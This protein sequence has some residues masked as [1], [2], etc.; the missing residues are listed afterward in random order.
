MQHSTDDNRATQPLATHVNTHRDNCDTHTRYLR[1]HKLMCLQMGLLP[2]LSTDMSSEP[3][4]V[5][6]VPEFTQFMSQQG[7]V[8]VVA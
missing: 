3:Q 6:T 5:D 4:E 8:P 2:L 7:G 1:K